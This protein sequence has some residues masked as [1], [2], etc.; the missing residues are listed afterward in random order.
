MLPPHGPDPARPHD[1]TEP[2]P[3]S[4]LGAEPLWRLAGAVDDV[5]AGAA[6][7]DGAVVRVVPEPT[8]TDTT[9]G[10][11]TWFPLDGGHPLDLLLGLVAP[12]HWAA[13]GVCCS[14]QAHGVD[15]AGTT[16]PDVTP[17]GRDVT[18][19]FSRRSTAETSDA[20]AVRITMLIDRAG[21][22]AGLLRRGG[23]VTPLPGNP[24]GTVADA[25]RRA[26]GLPTAPPPGS[27]AE[28][29]TLIWLDRVV[30][31]ASS[32]ATWQGRDAAW[33][34]LASLHPALGALTGPGHDPASPRQGAPATPTEV[35]DLVAGARALAAT[36]PWW[37]LREEPS[38]LG[39]PVE[40]PVGLAG[41]MD[42]GMFAR[43]LLGALPPAADLVD[44]VGALLPP[45][46]AEP[47][48][49]VTRSSL[50]DTDT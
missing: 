5:A 39:P 30:E 31:R 23:D 11:L 15:V 42:D 26:L 43:W 28:L 4:G 46:L 16:G 20:T 25:C 10:Q 37:R 22:T 21:T 41:W 12:P 48:V 19:R 8:A 34:H 18:A 29:W 6:R 44:A 38:G 32:R 9:S 47:I 13:L 3:S 33:A 40:L 49:A 24:E 27:T 45:A 50:D 1:P 7:D 2:A 36:W 14:G 17:P 35:A